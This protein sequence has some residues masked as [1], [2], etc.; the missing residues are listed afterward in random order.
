MLG[1]VAHAFSPSTWEVEASR[2]LLV[3]GQP[4]TSWIGQKHQSPKFANYILKMAQL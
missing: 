4:G 1:M 2:S 3:Q